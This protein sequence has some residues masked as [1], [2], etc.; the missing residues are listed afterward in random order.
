MAELEIYS[1]D[2]KMYEAFYNELSTTD[3]TQLEEMEL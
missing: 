1:V 2:Q 3:L